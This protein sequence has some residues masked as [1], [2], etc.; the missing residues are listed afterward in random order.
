MNSLKLVTFLQQ[1]SK[2]LFNL[3]SAKNISI[4]H[5]LKFNLNQTVS[6]SAPSTKSTKSASSTTGSNPSQRNLVFS[7]LDSSRSSN[8]N[9]KAENISRAMSYYLEKLSERGKLIRIVLAGKLI[10]LR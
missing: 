1:P 5:C 3:N 6:S 8:K 10:N 7:E 4:L 9:E 2:Y